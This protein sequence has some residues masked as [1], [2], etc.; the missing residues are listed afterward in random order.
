M[1]KLKI[2]TKK[3]LEKYYNPQAS[4]QVLGCIMKKPSLLKLNNYILDIDDFVGNRHRTLF[5]CIHNLIVQ[6]LQ[7]IKIADIETYLSVNDPKGHDLLFNNEQNIEWL[8]DI[9][10]DSN[11]VNFDYYYNS[12]RKMALLRNYMREGF[13]VS[14]MLDLDEIDPTLIRQQ[15]EK[16]EILTLLDIQKFFDRKNTSAKERFFMRESGSSRKAGDDAEELRK[17]LKENPCYGFG[18]E[19]EYLNTITR[20]ALG[21]K[22]FIET[23][24]SGLGK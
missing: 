11:E 10:E 24:D 4:C 17:K 22:F 7:E 19:S 5:F 3:Q 8:H 20:G 15:Q 14:C 2:V 13:D 9:L 12:V 16:F 1:T 6:G 23:R 18:L 21:G